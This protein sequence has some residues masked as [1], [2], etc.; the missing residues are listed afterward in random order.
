ME[1]AQPGCSCVSSQKAKRHV[2]GQGERI[3]VK[4]LYEGLRIRHSE[5]T[6]REV[7]ELCAELI[8]LSERTVYRVIK[9][10]EVSE[11]KAKVGRKKITVDNDTKAAIRRK[12]HGFFF[13]NEIPT[14]QKMLKEVQ[15]DIS[16]PNL[17]RQ[18]FLRTLR[19]MNFRHLKRNRKSV[20]IEKTK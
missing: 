2:L 9:Q 13:R 3:L 18:V 11:A 17:S 10:V 14:T 4:N 20:L 19:E 8:K 15:S 6:V 12:I 16:L 5:M 7:I 1:N